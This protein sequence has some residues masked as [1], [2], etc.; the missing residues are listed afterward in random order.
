M[1]VES[2][3]Q[4]TDAFEV[5]DFADAVDRILLS[6]AAEHL[7]STA[8]GRVVV[9]DDITGALSCAL[10]R[11]LGP[12]A[13]LVRVHDSLIGERAVDARLGE[14]GLEVASV[15]PDAAPFAGAEL[16]V[17]RLPVSLAALEDLAYAIAE[18]AAPGVRVLAGARIKHLSRGMNDVLGRHFVQ[19]DASLGRQNSRVLRASNPRPGPAPASPATTVLDDVGLTVCAYG[20][21]FAGAR[22]DLGTRLLLGTVDQWAGG[23]RSVVDLGCGT[24]LLAAAAARRLPAARVLAVDETWSAVRSTRATAVA[25][26][27]ADRI[28]V[29]RTDGLGAEAS[30]DLILCNPPFHRGAAKDS[31]TAF[32]MIQDAARTMRP[33]AELWLVY[34]AHLPYLPSLRR[35]GSTKIMA[36]D[37]SYLVTRTVRGARA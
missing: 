3:R 24:G 28:S 14:H 27:L 5:G 7:A 17:L 29:E 6:E 30:P 32:T 15:A 22:L 12:D 26:R 21:V 1:P 23:A 31:T 34:N 11:R 10:R 20:G 2:S 4:P 36:R 13:E 19:V 16:V 33:G 35:M 8:L 25:N 37:R 18:Q 9:V